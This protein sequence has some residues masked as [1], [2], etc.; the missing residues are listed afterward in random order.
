METLSSLSRPSLAEEQP[1]AVVPPEMTSHRDDVVRSGP[2]T[3]LA[4][5]LAE[6]GLTLGTEPI[7]CKRLDHAH[8]R[9]MFP[10]TGSEIECGAVVAVVCLYDLTSRLT[11]YAHTMHAGPDVNPLLKNPDGPM[12]TP[13]A[14]VGADGDRAT[15]RIVEQKK[16]LWS[17]FTDERST[18]GR[19]Q[20]ARRWRRDYYWALQRLYYCSRCSPCRW[21][22]PFFDGPDPYAAPK[23]VSFAQINGGRRVDPARAAQ[24]QNVVRHEAWR[25]E[26][27][28]A[29]RG[30]FRVA[31]RP[32]LICELDGNLDQM[33][34]ATD[35]RLIDT[36]SLLALAITYDAQRDKVMAAHCLS[37]GPDAE[38][39]FLR[40]AA[41]LGLPLPRGSGGS[42]RARLRYAAWRR[43]AWLTFWMDELEHGI[44]VA[45]ATWLTEFWQALERLFGNGQVVSKQPDCRENASTLRSLDPPCDGAPR[46]DLSRSP[47]SVPIEAVMSIGGCCFA[48]H[49]ASGRGGLRACDVST[50]SVNLGS[51]CNQTCH[52]CYIDAGPQR[53]E[54]MNRETTEQVLDVLC[55]HHIDTFDITGGA[56]EMNAHF[57]YLIENAIG[58]V[59]RIVDRCNL[60]ILLETG[61]EDLADFLAE[62]GVVVAASLPCYQEDNVDRQRGR[63][64]FAKSIAALRKLNE[65]GYGEPGTG[66]VLNLVFNPT[67]LGL[68][69][70]QADLEKAYRRE[71][72][73][74]FGIRFNRLLAMNNVPINRFRK[75]LIR[76]DGLAEYMRHLVDAFN[77]ATC[78]G[79]TCRRT[80]S[81]AW[82]GR[83]HDC[84][85]NQALGRPLA[86]GMPRMIREFD[87]AVLSGRL[88]QTGPHCFACAAGAGS[89]CNGALAAPAEGV[90]EHHP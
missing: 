31:D 41:S 68:A 61:Y 90:M 10:V 9:F 71:L 87:L 65:R 75:E 40:G 86:E 56:P 52:H 80:L 25:V 45:S 21:G 26:A 8:E 76:S 2:V 13:K 4:Q 62:H 36:G 69:P 39:Q 58:H 50:L 6:A 30:G 59:D 84:D 35:A 77:P 74:R 14:Q 37:A 19:E 3:S 15:R 64:T 72:N 20:A 29:L 81:V 70:S 48:G 82:D 85:F 38:I 47:E 51:R 5:R 83:L 57:R 67:T 42:E 18:L 1:A 73:G 55:R 23:A 78:A 44:E 46:S 43:E 54:Q 16:A 12:A 34:F 88:I 7:V 79:L 32:R 11:L 24:A 27:A 89:S 33:F 60:T 66:R 17:R 22:S 63:G 49:A 28:Y 53:A